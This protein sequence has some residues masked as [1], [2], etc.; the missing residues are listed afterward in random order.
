MKKEQA[1]MPSLGYDREIK[2]RLQSTKGRWLLLA[3]VM[4]W[5]GTSSMAHAVAV[6][7]SIGL[8]GIDDTNVNPGMGKVLTETIH[9]HL[10]NLQGI[11]F[12]KSQQ[13]LVEIK[14]VFNC[15]D[16]N[17]SC[18]AKVGKSLGVNRLIYGSI[19][20]Q[21]QG[22]LYLV[23]IKQL[24]VSDSTVEK[25]ITEAVSPEVLQRDNAQLDELVQRWVR[26]LLIE[27]LRGSLH[28]I[29]EPTAASVYLD[30]VPIGQTPLNV[31][32]LDVGDHLLKLETAGHVSITRTIHIRGG[33]VHEVTAELPALHGQ[34]PASR[35]GDRSRALRITSYVTAGVAGVLALAAIGTW[36]GY[37]GEEDAARNS[38]DQLQRSLDRTT[39]VS[40]R[41]FFE[42]SAQLSSCAQ[43]SG[44]QGNMYYQAYL[45]QCQ[46]GNTLARA[47][48]GLWIVAGGFAVASITTAILSSLHP[49]SEQASSGQSGDTPDSGATPSRSTPAT[50]PSSPSPESSPAVS[51]A[52]LQ[53]TS[54]VPSV[55][56]DG[57]GVAASFRF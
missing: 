47:T 55:G 52:A 11:Q 33:Q 16:E 34:R 36:R 1:S 45:S 2:R 51:A 57:A 31:T 27:A 19:R 12:E 44:L 10:P 56:P 39:L 50:S 32:D 46:H 48:T 17:P 23:A 14:L 13:D 6:P 30:G 35:P 43:V 24:N 42:S 3:A 25:F 53:L 38:L 4:A 54:L 8:L 18:M 49:S 9:R 22:S 41:G 37:V 15:T 29:S 21:P 40:N 28:V 7:I 26:V 5:L 20:K